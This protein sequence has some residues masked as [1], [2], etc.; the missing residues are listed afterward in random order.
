M[1]CMCVS[2][3]CYKNLKL[4][5]FMCLLEKYMLL[6]LDFSYMDG[7]VGDLENKDFLLLRQGIFLTF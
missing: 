2:F 4:S 5:G 1:V 7:G 6:D 3:L